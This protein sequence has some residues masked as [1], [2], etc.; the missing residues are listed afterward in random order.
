M[1]TKKK[2]K[3]SQTYTH[4]IKRKFQ[5][6][7]AYFYPGDDCHFLGAPGS[8]PGAGRL[9]ARQVG[10]GEPRTPYLVRV[11]VGRTQTVCQSLL[12]PAQRLPRGEGRCRCRRRPTSCGGKA[13]RCFSVVIPAIPA[14]ALLHRKRPAFNTIPR[15][16]PARQASPG[17]QFHMKKRPVVPPSCRSWAH[18]DPETHGDSLVSVQRVSC[19]DAGRP[20]CNH[21]RPPDS[22][23]TY[24]A[25]V[26]TLHAFLLQDYPS[27][28][29]K[30]IIRQLHLKHKYLKKRESFIKL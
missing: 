2:K 18:G 6:I 4:A 5:L 17:S 8:E 3:K 9:S 1:F 19:P 16:V 15:A 12:I 26:Y 29:V 20:G 7:N 22:R 24:A 14:T 30:F 13:A 21:A 23:K 27:I 28:R 10:C 11:L 25:R